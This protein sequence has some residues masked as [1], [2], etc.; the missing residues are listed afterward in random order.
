MIRTLLTLVLY[1]FLAQVLERSVLPPLRDLL[2]EAWA[3]L[4]DWR[5]LA[6]A[7]VLWGMLR[8]EVRGLLAAWLAALLLG[9]AL[10][11][12]QLG[13]TLVSFSLVAYLGGVFARHVRLQSWLARW[14][15]MTMLLIGERL[16]WNLL[17]WIYWPAPRF[18]LPWMSAI[19]T[20]LIGSAL[21]GALSPRLKRD[22]D[23]DADK[24]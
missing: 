12:G 13:V 16:V 19:L 15:W 18:D 11:P 5:L 24:R 7:G 20:A 9:L 23:A 14:M 10:P 6:L 17:H 3:F 2:P 22:L 8:G 4:L 1:L 21:Y